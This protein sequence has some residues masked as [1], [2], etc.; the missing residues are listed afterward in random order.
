MLENIKLNI[1]TTLAV[2]AIIVPV[3]LYISSITTKELTY[4]VVSKSDLIGTDLSIQ[5]IE[6]KI[7]GEAVSQATIH[8]IKLKNTGTE[9]IKTGDF[10][11]PVFIKFP[12]ETKIFN[13]Q[14][15]NKAPENIT[16]KYKIKEHAVSIEPFLFNPEEMFELEILASSDIYPAIDS[17]IS[18]V[19]DLEQLFPDSN[20]IVK[21]VIKVL[22]C[23][24]LVIYY[25]KS[26]KLTFSSAEHLSDLRVRFNNAVLTITCAA[27]SAIIINENR[28][29][30]SNEIFTNAVGVIGMMSGVIL[31][32]REEE[33][34]K[35]LNIKK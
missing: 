25:A 18:G 2:L 15:K 33:Y 34:N 32:M 8:L 14:E 16:L 12:E 24:F 17:R 9:P 3:I 4:Q 31:A 26:F 23:F 1:S 11:R 20:T 5:D 19:S 22:I 6:I 28:A 10:E 21:D 30:F 13:V 29:V 27:A 7:K 35:S